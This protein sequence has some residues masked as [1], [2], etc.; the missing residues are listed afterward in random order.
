LR[1]TDLKRAI[2]RELASEN[3][4]QLPNLFKNQPSKAVLSCLTGMIRRK[5]LNIR[6]KAAGSFGLVIKDLAE[7]D[8]EQAREI[9]RRLVWSL[10]EESG[11]IGW[12]TSEAM[13]ETF[14]NSPVL[15]AEFG[16]FLISYLDQ[17]HNYLEFT[18]LRQGVAWGL[19]RWAQRDPS[20]LRDKGV[21]KGLCELIAS[22]DPQL[23]GNA[24]WALGWLGDKKAQK[25]LSGLLQ[26]STKIFIWEKN[27][28]QEQE[29]SCLAQ[30]ALTRIDS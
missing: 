3:W 23:K 4:G 22:N 11:G 18:L 12:G 5:N 10:N 9:M 25:I 16:K 13:G 14:F 30:T 7:K 27:K 19:G 1:K 15:A 28:L 8:L 21:C 6:H 17:T 24:A 2:Y 29:L 20:H 26:D